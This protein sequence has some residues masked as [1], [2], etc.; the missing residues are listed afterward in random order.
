MNTHRFSSRVVGNSFLVVF[1]VFLAFQSFGLSGLAASATSSLD[2]Q[3]EGNPT[4]LTCSPYPIPSPLSYCDIQIVLLIDDSGSMQTNDPQFIKINGEKKPG[5]LRNQGAKNLVD[6][7]A[8]QYYLPAVQSQH[9]NPDL[10]LPEIRVAVIHFSEGLKEYSKEWIKIAPDSLEVWNNQRVELDKLIDWKNNYATMQYTHFIEPFDQA[11]KLFNLNDAQAQA[12][13]CIRK[14]ILLFTDGTP[15]DRYGILRDKKLDGEMDTVQSTVQDKLPKDVMIYVTGFKVNQKYWDLAAD[16]WKNIVGGED[17]DPLRIKLLEGEDSLVNLASRMEEITASLI[18]VQRSV[19]GALPSIEIPKHIQ[20]LRLT[21]YNLDPDTTLQIT[22]PNGEEVTADGEK[23]ILQG[24]D[25]S[26]IEVWELITPLAGSYKVQA[27]KPGGIITWLR[28]YQNLTVDFDSK[29][30]QLEV[31]KQ[32]DLKFK[33]VDSSGNMVLPGD[34]PAHT[35]ELKV[36]VTQAGQES[37]LP[38]TQEGDIYQISWTPTSPGD[39]Q[40]AVD[41]R[42]LSDNN[43]LLVCEGTVA[44][45]PVVQPIPPPILNITPPTDCVPRD[46]ATKVPMQLVYEGDRAWA[47]S[48]EWNVSTQTVPAG[49]TVVWSVNTVNANDGSYELIFD[50]SEAD[51][52]QFQVS[53]KALIE[54]QAV[55]ITDGKTHTISICIPAIPPDCCARDELWLFWFWPLVIVL[56][57][58]LILLLALRFWPEQT[59]TYYHGGR[60][61]KFRTS[62]W[63]LLFWPFL[64]L[65]SLLVVNRLWLC[66]IIPPWIFL[67]LIFVL[68]ILLLLGWFLPRGEPG[69]P[70]PR[71]DDL[72]R[73]EGIGPKVQDLFYKRDITTF[74]QLAQSQPVIEEIDAWIN[75]QGWEYMNPKTWPEQARLAAIARSSRKKEDWKK[76]EDYKQYLIKGLPPEDWPRHDD[77]TLIEG[78]GP[79]VQELFYKRGITSF[80]QLAESQPAIEEIDAWLNKQ[81]W[82]YMNPKTWAEQA[83]LADIASSSGKKEDWKKFEDFKQYLIKGLPPEDW[84]KK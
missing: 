69:H 12:G 54:G 30:S 13:D 7:L 9:E 39:S 21:L 1:L 64:I 82:E 66:C 4:A 78:I 81:G 68:L 84:S 20:L 56:V 74:E 23:V 75:K 16:H 72:T 79:K 62:Y 61:A 17:E 42:L 55:E 65:L 27:S 38:W 28:T 37:E 22:D 49:Q 48:L 15:E 45:L 50:P 8:R 18:G 60:R 11:A 5:N 6:L 63:H 43:E 10:R 80:A 51:E 29:P 76:F 52:I 35:L 26:S 73:I 57:V 25:T 41:A 2:F 33:L 14:S 83:R 59:D 24:E 19:L 34:D 58:L 32:S 67:V 70:H 36:F 71:H 47:G 31:S 53:A 46:Q 3:Q 40:F 44:E 77:L